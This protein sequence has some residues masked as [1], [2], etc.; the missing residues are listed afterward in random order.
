M[1]SRINATVNRYY[2]VN[3]RLEFANTNIRGKIIVA[4]KRFNTHLKDLL[5]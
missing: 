5:Y 2:T 1:Y 4:R 3:W